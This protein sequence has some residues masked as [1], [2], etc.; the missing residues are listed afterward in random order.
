[1]IKELRPDDVQDAFDRLRESEQRFRQ[2]AD[3]L[4]VGLAVHTAGEVVW[5]NDETVRLF[6]AANPD[7]LVGRNVYA[8][9]HPDHA[10]KSVERIARV[11]GKQSEAAWTESVFQRDDGTAFPVDVATTMIDWFGKPAA[12]AMFF[13]IGARKQAERERE[14]LLVRVADAQ[15]MESLTLLA[16]GVAHDF[17][18]LL[19]GILGNADLAMQDLPEDSPVRTRIAG[20]DLAARRAAELARQMLAYSGRG[21][22]VS[23]TLDPARVIDEAIR[24]ADSGLGHRAR[25]TT[26]V[27][28]DLP[29]FQA[30][31]IQLQQVLMNLLMNALEAVGDSGR[32]DVSA[33]TAELGQDD[34]DGG[35][36]GAATVPGRYVYLQVSDDGVGMDGKVL[37]RLFDPFFSTKFTGRGLGLAAVLGIVKGHSGAITVRSRPGAGASFRVHMPVAAGVAPTAVAP[38]GLDAAPSPGA[39]P[40]SSPPSTGRILVVDDEP[41]VLAIARLVLER[42]GHQVLVAEGGRQAVELLTTDP[43]AIDLVLLDLCMPQMDGRETLDALRTIRADLC[44]LL[45]SGHNEAQ[46]FSQIGDQRPD[47]F[48]RKP[49]RPRELDA[50]V[51]TLLAGVRGAAAGGHAQNIR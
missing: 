11:Y 3:N 50:A 32:I 39:D 41:T 14:A 51:Q 47:S 26:A 10:A 12:L 7:H 16:G 27:R 5:V 46:A 40:D 33:G 17:N 37:A 42:A 2:L 25:I 9:I 15:R 20:I 8:F 23:E 45:S 18:N 30:D 1:M 22:F 43:A 28:P 21:R 35:W 44:V 13:D 38:A 49:Y 4:P 19:V 36:H 24:L 29:A 48:L 6:G 34:L 31:P